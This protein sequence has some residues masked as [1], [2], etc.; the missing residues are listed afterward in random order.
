MA[1]VLLAH[2]IPTAAPVLTRPFIHR[3]GVVTVWERVEHTGA[4][5][6]AGALGRVAARLRTLR[7]S[8]AS[9]YDPLDK[10]CGYLAQPSVTAL[11]TIEGLQAF[12]D[13]VV[14]LRSALADT[15]GEQ[16]FVHGDLNPGNVLIRADGSLVVIDLEDCGYAIP[17][18]EAGHLLLRVQRL[19]EAPDIID[20]FAREYGVPLRPDRLALVRRIATAQTTSW[21]LDQH[22]R[23]PE[24]FPRSEIVLWLSMLFGQD[25]IRYLNSVTEQS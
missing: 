4:D 18:L 12:Q 23:D 10:V 13:E 16:V 24:Q 1:R 21:C 6:D 11:L 8:G 15:A 19:G 9:V 5:A 17:E 3:E 7:P 25:A 20:V 14:A 22:L 2:G